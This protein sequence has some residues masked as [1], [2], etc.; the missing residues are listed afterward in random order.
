MRLCCT[1]DLQSADT[2][3]TTQR[4]RDVPGQFYKKQDG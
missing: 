3:V 2:G 4:S 1:V